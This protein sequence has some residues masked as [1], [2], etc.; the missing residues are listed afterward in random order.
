MGKFKNKAYS[1]W[2]MWR[3]NATQPDW[4][5]IGKINGVSAVMAEDMARGWEAE[6]ARQDLEDREPEWIG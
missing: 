5:K 1:C 6:M 4:D 2:E 3:A